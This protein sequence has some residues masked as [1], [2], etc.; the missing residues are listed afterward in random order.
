MIHWIGTCFSLAE[1]R[2]V[3]C[4][5]CLLTNVV[6]VPK[7]QLKQKKLAFPGEDEVK[8]SCTNRSTA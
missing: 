6:I 8:S 3:I 1:R 2:L 5:E 7:K 4:D